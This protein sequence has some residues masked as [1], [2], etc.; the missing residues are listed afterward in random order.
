MAQIRA[1]SYTAILTNIAKSIMRKWREPNKTNAGA[2]QKRQKE[3][4][5]SVQHERSK[6]SMRNKNVS[7]IRQ[8]QSGPNR[9]ANTSVL[10]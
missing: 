5:K 2:I 10:A 3:D 4:P 8:T 9:H 7:K 6:P 1:C